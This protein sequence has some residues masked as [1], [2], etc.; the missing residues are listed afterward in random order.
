MRSYDNK[1]LSN[2][3]Q[4]DAERIVEHFWMNLYTMAYLHVYSKSQDA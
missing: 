4:T 1:L 2:P 3:V